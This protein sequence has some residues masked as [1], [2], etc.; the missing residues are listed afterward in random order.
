[1]SYVSAQD[2]SDAVMYSLDEVQGTARFRG[3]SGAFVALGGDLS[4]VSIN[5]AGAAIFNR[6]GGSFS[7]SNLN[8]KNDVNYFNGISSSS[9]SKFDINQLGTVFVFNNT[10]QNSKWKKMALTI[11]YDK[12]SDFDNN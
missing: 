3:M 12:V 5:P 1:M 10:N 9:D 6:S 7:L 4:A 11:N 8:T 2:I